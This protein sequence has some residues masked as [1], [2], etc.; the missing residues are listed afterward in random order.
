MTHNT[1][2]HECP[3]CYVMEQSWEDCPVCGGSGRV[4]AHTL[5]IYRDGERAAEAHWSAPEGKRM[6]GIASSVLGREA[7]AQ[8][9]AGAMTEGM[10]Q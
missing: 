10:N 2:D 5:E 7:D 1:K 6:I 9:S 3:F 8:R 4:S